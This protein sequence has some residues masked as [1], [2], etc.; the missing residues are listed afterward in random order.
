MA[1]DPD[2][3]QEGDLPKPIASTPI[4]RAAGTSS[5]CPK[6]GEVVVSGELECPNC[7]QRLK[8][9]G[10]SQQ[11]MIWIAAAWLVAS[12]LLS[13]SALAIGMVVEGALTVFCVLAGLPLLYIGVKALL[14]RMVGKP[15]T[16][17][18]LIRTSF[19]VSVAAFVL[20]IG[21]PLSL[22][23]LVLIICSSGGGPRHMP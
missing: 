14:F 15:L 13:L 6:C 16:Q 7:G 9:S 18:Q 4:A 11:T 17:D 22:V 1:D 5:K 19:R 20:V 12:S 23:L 21:L 2:K 10:L 3:A 8:R